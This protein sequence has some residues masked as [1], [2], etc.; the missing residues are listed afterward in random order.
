[1]IRPKTQI[2]R[3]KNESNC[4]MV[5][6]ISLH[7]CA[8]INRESDLGRVGLGTPTITTSQI[9]VDRRDLQLNFP[10]AHLGEQ[11]PFLHP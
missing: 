3:S 5:L 7:I 1:M 4:V 9:T 11:P 6:G 10:P 2:N 8:R